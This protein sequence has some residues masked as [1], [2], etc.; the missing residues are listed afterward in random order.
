MK[1]MNL[2]SRLPCTLYQVCMTELTELVLAGVIGKR[3]STP[4]EYGRA[5]CATLVFFIFQ[6]KM[7]IIL[8]HRLKYWKLK[9]PVMIISRVVRAGS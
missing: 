6:K 9:T 3:E 5:T 8:Q 1:P 2:T 4:C 7:E